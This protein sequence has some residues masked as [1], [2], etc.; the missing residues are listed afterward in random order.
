MRA[1]RGFGRVPT[2]TDLD[3]LRVC[4]LCMRA[5]ASACTLKCAACAG[6]APPRRG[7]APM[8]KK[9]V[10]FKG[11]AVVGG[12]DMKK[13]KKDVA[14]SAGIR[15]ACAAPRERTHLPATPRP[16]PSPPFARPP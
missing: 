15:C 14:Q 10:E 2:H 9:K 12:K 5:C 13:L 7:A 4:R 16:R 3:C 11:S 1:T 6:S 8:F